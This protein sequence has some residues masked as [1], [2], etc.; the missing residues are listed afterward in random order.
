MDNDADKIYTARATS[1]TFL[2]TMEFLIHQEKEKSYLSQGRT[3]NLSRE[4]YNAFTFVNVKYLTFEL[5]QIKS[6]YTKY[7]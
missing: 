5:T 6:I 2:S 7:I 4:K 3:Q 1:T